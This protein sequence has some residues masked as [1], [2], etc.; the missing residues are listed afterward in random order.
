ML[1]PALLG[2]GAVLG[3]V[4]QAWATGRSPD[5]LVPGSAMS[6]TGSTLVPLA[7]AL[8]LVAAAAAIVAVTGGRVVR[9]VA[10]AVLLLAGLGCAA[11]VGW[12][13]ADPATP[14]ADDLAARS[15]RSSPPTVTATATWAAWAALAASLAPVAAGVLAL[16]HAGETRGLSPRYDAPVSDPTAR[17]TPRRESL[18]DRVSNEQADDEEPP[19]GAR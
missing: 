17:E 9:F 11:A 18:W 14:L 1:L 12:F 6:A 13:L 15:G 5:A 8:T 7:G 4:T 16:R 10:A 3:L 19:R 2:A